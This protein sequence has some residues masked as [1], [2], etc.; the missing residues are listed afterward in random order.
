MI[1]EKCS[2]REATI[3]LT[4]IIKDVKSE[5]HLCE[6]CAREIGFNSKLS[7][8]TISISEMLTF[9]DN[10]EVL[11]PGSS[12]CANCGFSL[13]EYRS[14]GKL[15]CPDCYKHFR[16]FLSP[17][18]LSIHGEKKHIGKI[19]ANIS[20]RSEYRSRDAGRAIKSK[21]LQELQSELESAVS[22]ER[23]EDA[24]LIRNKI[25]DITGD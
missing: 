1:C 18:L 2:V 24:A 5:I 15:G 4:E 11:E 21:P 25:K 14:S 22:E 20:S 13:A 8:F 19:P 10:K 16:D 9:L 7:N 17:I 6:T 3:H 12:Y 23:Y